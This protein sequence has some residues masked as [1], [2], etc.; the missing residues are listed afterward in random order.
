MQLVGRTHSDTNEEIRRCMMEQVEE[1]AQRFAASLAEALPDVPK[2]VLHVRIHFVVGAMAHT[3]AFC[4]R[5]ERP[6]LEPLPDP[7]VVLESLVEFALAGL[8]APVGSLVALE[9]G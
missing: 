7:E 9:D 2:P 1:V 5:A 4:R 3:F 8:V 6:L